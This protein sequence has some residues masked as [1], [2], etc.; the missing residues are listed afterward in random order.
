M[1]IPKPKEIQVKSGFYQLSP[2]MGISTV[3]AKPEAEY[4][5]NQLKS[6]LGK[7]FKIGKKSG[8]ISIFITP[9]PKLYSSDGEAYSISIGKE[10]I[11]ISSYDNKGALYGVQTLLQLIEEHKND[12]Q[13]PYLDIEDEPKF[14][15]RGMHLD[16]ARHFF[17]V[18]EVKQYLDYLAMYKYNKF[19]WHLT[20]DQGWRIEI[21][22]YPK[23]TSVGAWRSGSQVGPYSD[24]KFDSKPY[25]GFYT[26]EQI[27]DVVAYA[28]K[29]HIDVV[30]EIEM[31][32]HAQAALAAYPELGCTP[33][34]F[35]VWKQWGVSEDI[36][37]PKE[38]TFKFLQDVIDEVIPLFPYEYIHIGG[39]EAPKKRWKESE[40]VQNLM[41]KLNIPDELHMQSYFITRMEKYI[42]SKGKKII[43]WDEILEGG[44]APNATVMSW[45]GIEGGI[46]AAK[47]GHKAVMT[48]TSTNYF[49]YYQG[50][51]ETEPLAIGGNVRLNKVY[52]YNPIP[53]ELTEEQAKFIWGT[54]ANLWTEYIPNFSQVQYM[55]FPRM[56]ALSE[57]AW[58]TANPKEYKNFESRVIQHFK[59]LDRKGINYSRAIYE[60][61]G[62][63]I[64]QPD[65]KILYE[66][67]SANEPQNIR[68][69]LDG[70][71]PT[72]NSF[73]YNKPIEI[74]KT[75]TVKASYFEDGKKVSAPLIQDFLI[76]KSTGKPITLQDDP[77][78][79]YNT[80]GA[81]TL[82]DGI[83]GNAKNFG[84]SWL[85]FS[86]KDC[87]ATIDL[88]TKTDFSKISF[89]SVDRKGSWIYLPKGAKI[90]VSD[91]GVNFKEVK[92]ITAAEIEKSQG[93]VNLDFPKQNARYVKVEI[94]NLGL[95]PDGLPGAGNKAWLFVDEIAVQ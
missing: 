41:K 84:K 59:I 78:E 75:T 11:A 64:K 60:V 43:G 1:L 63:V 90:S 48:P 51:P 65:G 28:K 81:F 2:E 9:K 21:K 83:R 53:A 92:S 69:T 26:Q 33:G 82:V 68:Y 62:K 73:T 3:D 55:V 35:E 15:Y 50:N 18:E 36:F 19:H 17:T 86:G 4:L 57:V 40:F 7:D 94:Q 54:Q 42:N 10:G 49:D 37:C 34:P 66:L 58:G 47:T 72:I 87:V 67:S 44:L 95:I 88:G 85:G 70:S 74:T 32:G 56:M 76:T 52:N 39:D 23:L 6:M 14:G 30:P 5:Q 31:P 71:E 27:K 20:D 25:G 79:A 29:L 61:D 22:K 91:D 46:H 77:A 80:G 8:G 38:E 24:M 12:L 93:N 89:S 16:V 45:T 13:L